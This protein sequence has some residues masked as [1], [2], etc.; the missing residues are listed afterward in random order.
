MPRV[1][2]YVLSASEP[3]RTHFAC[4]LTEKAVA[5]GNTVFLRVASAELARELDTLL[6]T[7]NDRSFLPHEIVGQADGSATGAPVLIG[8]GNAP[9]SHRQL[10]VNLTSEMPEDAGEFERIAELVDDDPEGKRLARSR[11]RQ[12]RDRG[13]SPES[14]N[15]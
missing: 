6:W 13:W 7:F 8:T 15:L 1:D 9:S 5:H 12:Y 10:L 11:F 14:H 4:R 3:S 2:F